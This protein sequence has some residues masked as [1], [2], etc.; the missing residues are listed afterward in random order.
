MERKGGKE[1][2]EKEGEN[3]KQID[4]RKRDW[5]GDHT[6]V[7]TIFF[8]FPI[9]HFFLPSSSSFVLFLFM[10]SSRQRGTPRMWQGV[11]QWAFRCHGISKHCAI[12]SPYFERC[13]CHFF[14]GLSAGFK[15][16]RVEETRRDRSF[17][18]TNLF[19]FFHSFL[20]SFSLY[21]PPYRNPFAK[22][23]RDWTIERLTE[24]QNGRE[25]APRCETDLAISWLHDYNT[26][27]TSFDTDHY[28]YTVVN[29]QKNLDFVDSAR[30]R[31]LTI[32]NNIG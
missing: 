12:P 18:E 11:R 3:K 13:C 19:L 31:D 30:M 1:E 22:T 5:R 32:E 15:V 10:D 14:L 16:D 24:V 28:Q 29:R 4:K 9:L 25:L 17:L 20:L 6:L 26:R 27:G 23:F 8:F 21:P 7:C 2:K